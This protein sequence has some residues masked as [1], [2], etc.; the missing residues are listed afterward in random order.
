MIL[1]TNMTG[2]LPM[3]KAPMTLLSF[4]FSLPSVFLFAQLV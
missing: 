4:S 3:P 1:S 2:L